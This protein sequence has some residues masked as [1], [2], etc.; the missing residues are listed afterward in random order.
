[1]IKNLL[2]V[3]GLAVVIRQA[4]DHYLQFRKLQDENAYWHR[5]KKEKG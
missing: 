2:A 3:V 5:R 1:M 4:Y